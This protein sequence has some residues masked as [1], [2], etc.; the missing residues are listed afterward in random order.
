MVS[1]FIPRW[2]FV[3]INTTYQRGFIKRCRIQCSYT[4]YVLNA[5][6]EGGIAKSAAADAAMFFDFKSTYFNHNTYYFL[7]S[8][9]LL[10]PFPKKLPLPVHVRKNKPF[11]QV[12]WVFPSLSSAWTENHIYINM[13]PQNRVYQPPRRPEGWMKVPN[14]WIGYSWPV[15]ETHETDGLAGVYAWCLT[16]LP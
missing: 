1:H 6:L 13:R 12:L 11:G 8:H 9:W 5:R 15:E 14:C 7:N 4:N 2:W 10:I 16:I 3:V